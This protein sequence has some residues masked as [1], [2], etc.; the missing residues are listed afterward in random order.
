MSPRAPPRTVFKY[1][2]LS[3]CL[4]LQNAWQNDDKSVLLLVLP[5]WEIEAEIFFFL[6]VVPVVREENFESWL[7]VLFTL[8]KREREAPLS[9]ERR[10]VSQWRQS[11]WHCGILTLL[12]PESNSEGGGSSASI[13]LRLP[14]LYSTCCYGPTTII[15]LLLKYYKRQL[16]IWYISV[17]TCNL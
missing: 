13:I 17:S 6:C 7:T 16:E 5:G 11:H 1:W 8:G 12:R 2:Y 3:H 15:A 10:G 4:F 9:A 14:T